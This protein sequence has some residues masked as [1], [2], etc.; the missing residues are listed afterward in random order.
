M[1]TGFLSAQAMDYLIFAVIMI[2]FIAC[3]VVL[4]RLQKKG[5]KFGTRVLVALA[6]GVVLGLIIQFAFGPKAPGTV[7]AVSWI[8]LVGRIYVALLRM[9]VYP[10]APRTGV[11]G[12]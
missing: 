5:V 3:I 6:M 12:H 2:L 4:V 1:F 8:N 11:A 9:I 7:L 10:L